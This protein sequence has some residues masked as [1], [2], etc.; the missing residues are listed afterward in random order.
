MG[1]LVSTH[2][3]SYISW[4]PVTAVWRVLWLKME[5]AASIYRE[6]CEYNEQAVVESRQ[7]VVLQFERCAGSQQLLTE[8]K[9]LVAKCHTR[10]RTFVFL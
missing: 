6:Y 7:G 8:R 5:E 9:H 4:A 3:C 2:L 1:G 10:P